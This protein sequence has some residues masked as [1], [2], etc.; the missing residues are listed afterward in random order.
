[1]GKMLFVGLGRYFCNSS[2]EWRYDSKMHFNNR[3]W[4][5]FNQVKVELVANMKVLSAHSQHGKNTSSYTDFVVTPVVS[6]VK[7]KRKAAA[8]LRLN[9][10][11]YHPS[12]P[13]PHPHRR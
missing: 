11:T 4:S 7:K 5:A 12:L 2:A 1:M 10:D 8:A 9:F 6:L 3:F 13:V